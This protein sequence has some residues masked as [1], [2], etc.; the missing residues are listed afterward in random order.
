M[1]GSAMVT[2]GTELF[3]LNKLLE[4]C[5]TLFLSVDLRVKKFNLTR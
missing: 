5:A 3:C 4:I 1:I 2:M